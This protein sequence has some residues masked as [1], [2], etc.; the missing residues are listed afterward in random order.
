MSLQALVLTSRL[1]RRARVIS[2][3]SV[4]GK[5]EKSS[6]RAYGTRGLFIYDNASLLAMRVLRKATGHFSHIHDS[7]ARIYF[8]YVHRDRSSQCATDR[9]TCYEN[10]PACIA[11]E[12]PS[13]ASHEIVYS[14]LIELLRLAL[15]SRYTLLLIFTFCMNASAPLFC[16]PSPSLPFSVKGTCLI[17]L[18]MTRHRARR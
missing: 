1:V 15:L 7:L 9:A 16:S 10:C 4:V 6:S 3:R 13:G 18:C 8:Q 2:C 5:R 12:I 17:A 14:Y 11:I